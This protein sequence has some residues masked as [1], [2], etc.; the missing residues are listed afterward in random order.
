MVEMKNKIIY[1]E[2]DIELIKNP[3]LYKKNNIDI[4]SFVINAYFYIQKVF[5]KKF[6]KK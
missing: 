5:L 2:Q 3:F 4:K 6:S 1:I